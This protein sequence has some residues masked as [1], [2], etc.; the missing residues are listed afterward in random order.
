MVRF[1]LERY[2]CI[3]L[4]TAFVEL[5]LFSLSL[6]GKIHADIGVRLPLGKAVSCMG[7]TRLT[8]LYAHRIR[9]LLLESI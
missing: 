9:S 5:V 7:T 3:S 4:I 8:L 6:L 2:G 1:S